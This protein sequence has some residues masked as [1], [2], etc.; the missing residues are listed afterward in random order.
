LV[1]RVSKELW[2]L[3]ALRVHQDQLDKQELMAIKATEDNQDK[4]EQQVLELSPATV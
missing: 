3:S 1:I 2:D 4:R